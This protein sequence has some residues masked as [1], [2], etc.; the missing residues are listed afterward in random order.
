MQAVKPGD[1]KAPS[2][3]GSTTQHPFTSQIAWSFFSAPSKPLKQRPSGVLQNGALSLC[4]DKTCQLGST[5]LIWS[6][7]NRLGTIL[8]E[9]IWVGRSNKQSWAEVRS[10]S[11]FVLLDNF[12]EPTVTLENW[13]SPS[14]EKPFQIWLA[15]QQLIWELYTWMFP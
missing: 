6:W 13:K 3:C 5:R 10:A 2:D 11:H 9:H 8:L 7:K 15:I 4:T 1:R 14:V 12:Q